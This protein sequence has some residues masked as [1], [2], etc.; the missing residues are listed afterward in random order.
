MIV[1]HVFDLIYN[2]PELIESL[3][4]RARPIS[5]YTKSKCDKIDIKCC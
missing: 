3:N 5:F 1:K 2:R 4:A